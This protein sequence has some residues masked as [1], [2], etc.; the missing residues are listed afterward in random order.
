MRQIKFS[1]NRILVFIFALIALNIKFVQAQNWSDSILMEQSKT[2][3]INQ[4]KKGVN[5]NALIFA[6]NEYVENVSL[7]SMRQIILGTPFFLNDSLINGM[8]NY[9]G[10]EYNLPIK[11]HINDQKLILNHPITNTT[12]E[13]FNERIHHFSIGDHYFFKTPKELLRLMKIEQLYAERM[14]NDKFELWVIHDK[15][16]KPTKK[17]EEQTSV[18]ISYDQYAVHKNGKWSK[19]KSEQ[20]LLNFCLDK[21]GLVKAYLNELGLDLKNNFDFS[22]LK[23]LK[24]YN[25]IS[26]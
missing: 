26:D 3:A 4:F 14:I 17:A 1:L 5:E 21:K 18:Y 19:L 8:V 16:L 24:Y 13:L 23:A 12:I 7:E 9:N 15:K 10:I 20:D 11:F 6:G 25:T 22:L 2:N